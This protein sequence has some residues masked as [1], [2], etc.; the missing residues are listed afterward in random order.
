M[1]RNLYLIIGPSG[2]GKSK[3]AETLEYIFQAQM[4]RS[5]TTRKP[6]HEDEHG[7][8]FLAEEDFD[9]LGEL[10]AYTEFDGH[11]YGVTKALLDESDIYV[12]DPAGAE[13]LHD[14]YDLTCDRDIIPIILDC[15]ADT[16]VKRMDAQGRNLDEI[17]NRM[18]HDEKIFTPSAYATLMMIYGFADTFIIDAS[19]DF[20]KV[21]TEV[22][23]VILELEYR[24]PAV[25]IID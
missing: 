19:Q 1:L 21:L 2:S 3:L 11:R 22:M 16:C 6:R 4:V 10:V 23:K 13:V 24:G 17:Y 15:D 8:I 7:H 12:I 5:Y 20:D 14:R 9:T 25:G 18:A